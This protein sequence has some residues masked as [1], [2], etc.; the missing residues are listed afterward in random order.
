M[1][2]KYFWSWYYLLKLIS[3]RFTHP[4]C[5]NLNIAFRAKCRFLIQQLESN[6][7]IGGSKRSL[8]T[9]LPESNFFIF[10][11]FSAKIAHPFWKLAPSPRKILDP[12]LLNLTLFS[13]LNQVHRNLKR[14]WQLF[15]LPEYITFLL[16]HFLFLPLDFVRLNKRT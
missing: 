7:Y 11:Q 12:P 15:D 8:G 4:Q 13:F 10:V 2:Q 3:L 6:F 14:K 16:T 1:F 5:V 9:P